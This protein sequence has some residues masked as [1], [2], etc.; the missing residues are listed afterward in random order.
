M[1]T[2]KRDLGKQSVHDN[3]VRLAAQRWA[4]LV[5]DKIAIN[6]GSDKNMWA[7]AGLAN[8]YPDLVGWS[9]R[10]GR[11]LLEWVAE[12]ETEESVS[13]SEA[14]SQWQNNASLGVPFY[15]I[16]PKGYKKPQS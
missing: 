9:D 4:N 11:K 15:L 12:V 2:A 8:N 13:Y 6:P 5:T 10:S 7:W 16:V 14:R 3:I 1:S